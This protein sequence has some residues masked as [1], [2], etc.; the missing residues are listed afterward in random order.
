MDEA[1]Q[2][3]E[4]ILITLDDYLRDYCSRLSFG[5]VTLHGKKITHMIRWLNTELDP[6]VVCKLIDEL[7]LD[8]G[9]VIKYLLSRKELNP[10]EYN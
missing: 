9:D 8:H 5:V 1:K 4:Q 7:D 2:R 3:T 10:K 6:V